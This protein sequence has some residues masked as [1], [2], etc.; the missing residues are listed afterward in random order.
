MI[1]DS[2]YGNTE[3]VAKAFEAGL[4]RAGVQTFVVNAKE[5]NPQTIQEYD[6]IAVGAPTEKF[7][8]SESIKEF[9]ARL[10]G[11]HF[12]GKFG[13]AFDTRFSTR[14][15]GSAAKYIEKKQSKLGLEIILERASAI[16]VSQ[17]EKQGGIMLKDSEENRLEEIGFQVGTAFLKA[18]SL[19]KKEAVPAPMS[20]QA[21]V[22][23]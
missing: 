15:A 18:I 2:R 23:S 20:I 19:R 11:M 21:E 6:L 22:K 9:L 1:F 5:V 17:K 16:V 14:L 3:R 13:F 7:T 12:S 4:K 8:A 10:E